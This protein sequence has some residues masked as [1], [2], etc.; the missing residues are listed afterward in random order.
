MNMFNNLELNN[1]YNKINNLIV[2]AKEFEPDDELRSHLSKYIC[3][4]CSG[5]IENS[6]YHT[7]SDIIDRVCEPSVVV[8]YTKKQLYKLQN[9]NTGKIRDVAESFNTDWWENKLKVFL[10]ENDRAGSINYIFKE[11]HNIAHGRNSEITINILE[12]HF[13]KAVDVIKY[14]ENSLV[15]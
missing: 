7:F 2:L 4:I 15:D 1:Q 8:Q 6:M 11:R 9:T 10:H 12:N 3:V 14:I 5:F 13:S